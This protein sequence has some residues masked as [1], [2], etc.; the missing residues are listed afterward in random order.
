MRNVIVLVFLFTSIIPVNS[1]ISTYSGS[2]GYAGAGL[3]QVEIQFNIETT[4]EAN[5]RYT[6]LYRWRY[7]MGSYRGLIFEYNNRAYFGKQRK[8]ENS[9]WFVQG[10]I[11]HGL[12]KGVNYDA[13][14]VP[15]YSSN[16]YPLGFN[17]EK[18]IDKSHYTIN[19]GLAVGYKW[20]FADLLTLDWNLG[21]VGFTQ[22]NFSDL[23]KEHEQKRIKDW[24]EGVASK[25]EFQWS[26]GFFID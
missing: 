7:A 8:M 19:Y 3:D 17:S 13:G 6:Q 14:A 1:Q 16:G 25:V 4:Y 11:G 24:N 23:S 5:E 18:Y 22:P 15:L 12:L 9:K 10:K 21:Y 2:Y 26:L 20:V